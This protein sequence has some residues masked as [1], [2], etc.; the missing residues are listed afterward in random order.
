MKF[1]DS[2]S[3]EALGKRRSLRD[4]C[5]NFREDRRVNRDSKWL[6]LGVEDTLHVVHRVTNL[7]C[8]SVLVLLSFCSL[9]FQINCVFCTNIEQM[10]HPP[11]F[12]FAQSSKVKKFSTRKAWSRATLKHWYRSFQVNQPFSAR[13]AIF[14][15]RKKE[16]QAGTLYNI[17]AK[18]RDPKLMKLNPQVV[19]FFLHY[20]QTEQI[21]P[22]PLQRDTK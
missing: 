11:K 1:A 18:W 8:L 7:L 20:H 5:H 22:Q 2:T 12:A 16:H 14:I 6:L 10:Q 17:K 4:S 3:S 9:S 19:G 21:P 13:K 15:T